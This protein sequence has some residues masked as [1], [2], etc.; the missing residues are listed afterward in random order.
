M[1]WMGSG[2]DHGLGRGRESARFFER[3][4]AMTC[5]FVCNTGPLIAP[6]GAGKLEMPK[7]LNIL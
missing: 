6:G 3:D 1:T 4:R 5:R 2:E 7:D